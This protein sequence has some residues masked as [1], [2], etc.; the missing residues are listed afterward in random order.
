MNPPDG[1]WDRVKPEVRDRVRPF[2][3]E[4][5]PA[6]GP[7]L[8]SVTVTGRAVLE[9]PDF[10][11]LGIQTVLV[12]D[13]VALRH[14]ETIAP[15]GKRHG[16]K[17]LSAP[18]LMSAR[19]VRE[20]LDVFPLEFLNIRLAHV[21][22]LGKD[23]FRDLE[24]PRDHLRT[25]CER[26]IKTFLIRLR[27]GYL[28]STGEGR[29]LEAVVR[30]ASASFFSIVRGMLH[31]TGTEISLDEKKD[32]EAIRGKLGIAAEAVYAR[33]LLGDVRA[34]PKENFEKFYAFAEQLAARV[35]EYVTG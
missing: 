28:S 9:G 5:V 31:L 8:E 14:V 24:I 17:G 33:L 16:K 18:L 12:F 30:E 27:Q 32:A 10:D 21:T 3:E 6:I 2:V 4:V 1:G 29:A 20:S 22:V 35:N 15:L 34:H 25:Q 7:S 23:L 19:Y 11:P 26:E 13:E